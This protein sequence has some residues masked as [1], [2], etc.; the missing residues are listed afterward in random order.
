M[1]S[2]E[3]EI[4]PAQTALLFVDVQVYNVRPTGGQY[5]AE[6]IGPAEARA[7]YAYFFER[8]EATVIPNMRHLQRACRNA[9]VEVIYTVIESL[10]RDGRDRSLDYK[11]SGFN[12]TRGSLDGRVIDDIAPQGD[13]MVFP[14]SSSSPFI[15]TN[16]HYVLGNLGVRYLIVSGLLTDQCISS[17][18]RD[19]CDLGYLVTLVPDACATRTQERHDDA[20]AHI[21][22]YCRSRS[23]E[24]LLRELEGLQRADR[25]DTALP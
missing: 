8:L 19:A 1:L 6:G 24:A 7:K 22:G 20:I 21:G 25:A 12:I 14:K 5:R 9:G 15:S 17:T 18:V 10:T 2:R 11:I 23:T 16:L 3:V 13:E 4:V